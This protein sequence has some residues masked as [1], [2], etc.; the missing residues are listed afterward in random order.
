M[1]TLLIIICV[2]VGIVGILILIKISYSNGIIENKNL[3]KRNWASVIA[4]VR[5]K[6]ELLP[7]L[8]QALTNYTSYEG[9]TIQKIIEIRKNVPT[10]T[11]TPN[12]LNELES[13]YK[14]AINAFK[15]EVEAYPELKA[16][17]LYVNFMNSNEE[18]EANI[19]SAIEIYNVTV[20]RF[21][22]S[23]QTFPG[24]YINRK[25]NK[26]NVINEFSHSSA[27]ETIGYKPN[28]K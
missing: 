12:Q 13:K 15:V 5:K 7:S 18:V 19:V 4:N 28:F 24:S 21:N 3:V 9:E 10:T 23:I 20:Q 25:W 2:I 1:N 27:E 17:T 22:N 6:I 8:Q 14:E 16:N 11:T 26:E